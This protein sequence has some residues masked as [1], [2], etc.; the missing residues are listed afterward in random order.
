MTEVR[1]LAFRLK[2]TMLINFPGSAEQT[3]AI[4]RVHEAL[5]YFERAVMAEKTSGEPGVGTRPI[6]I[7][8]LTFSFCDD[9]LETGTRKV[10]APFLVKMRNRD[11]G[12]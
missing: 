1:L 10:P 9:Q 11:P 3:I 8:R 7:I 4:R 6:P 2:G 12:P 5:M